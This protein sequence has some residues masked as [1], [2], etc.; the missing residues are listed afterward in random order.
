MRDMPFDR[1]SEEAQVGCRYVIE[2]YATYKKY[3]LRHGLASLPVIFTLS[4]FPN[5]PV[6]EPFHGGI[7]AAAGEICKIWLA[8]KV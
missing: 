4:A 5:Q 8:R 2:K 7:N 6:L 3:A 1:K